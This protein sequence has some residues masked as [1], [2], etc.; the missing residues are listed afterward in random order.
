MRIEEITAKALKNVDN[1]KY[2]LAIAVSKRAE[3][4]NKGA[5]PL[6]NMDPHKS[7]PADIAIYEL[8]EGVLKVEDIID[9]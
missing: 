2:I 8:A 3:E 1:D 4:I 9:K 6:V 5:K 7:K